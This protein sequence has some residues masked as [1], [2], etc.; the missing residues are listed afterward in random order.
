MQIQLDFRS[1]IPIYVQI[2]DQIKNQLAT[3]VLKPN[4]QLPTVRQLASDLRV[5]FNT[6][7]R[8]YR[9][10]DETG[11]IST[12]HGRGTYIL[13]PPESE[14]AEQ[15]KRQTLL[16]LTCNYLQQASRLGLTAAEVRA[17]IGPLLEEWERQG[18]ISDKENE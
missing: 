8:A 5:N 7:A 9:L 6:V 13:S 2:M 18:F 16:G 1:G 12:Q 15:L 11:L 10:L 3:G 17:T 4:D 14:A